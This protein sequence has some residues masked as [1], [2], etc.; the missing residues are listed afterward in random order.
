MSAFEPGAG[1][2][3]VDMKWVLYFKRPTFLKDY[4]QS[5]D[6]GY[7]A[8]PIDSAGAQSAQQVIIERTGFFRVGAVSIGQ[9]VVLPLV[10]R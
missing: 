9:R 2:A 1:S 3:V 5:I 8:P 7:A 4:V 10:K 6:I